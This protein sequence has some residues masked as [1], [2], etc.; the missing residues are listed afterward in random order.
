MPVGSVEYAVIAFPGNRFNGEIIPAI[1]QLVDDGIVRILD[2]VFVIKDPAGETQAVE[3][4]AFD[5]EIASY[6][7]GWD[8]EERGLFNQDDIEDIAADLDADS[9][10]ALL[11]WENVWSARFAAAVM[12]SGGVL[13]A[14]E[15]ISAD[16]VAAA[17][18]YAESDEAAG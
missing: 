4:S 11:V 3:L 17:L 10:A 9:S 5:P 13:V 1:R 7:A 15:K 14:T 8:H 6:F 16:I 2:L 18:E 12:N